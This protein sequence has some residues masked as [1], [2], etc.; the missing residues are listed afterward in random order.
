MQ[1]KL[2]QLPQEV[3]GLIAKQCTLGLLPTLMRVSKEFRD[4]AE[5][6]LFSRLSID[7]SRG[8][9]PALIALEA[10]ITRAAFAQHLSVHFGDFAIFTNPAYGALM[11]VLPRMSN[12]TDLRVRFGWRD[13]ELKAF[14]TVLRARV[15]RLVTLFC[16]IRLDL[17]AVVLSQPAL[18]HLGTYSWGDVVNVSRWLSSS[19]TICDRSLVVFSLERTSYMQYFTHLTVYQQPSPQLWTEFGAVIQC[20]SG[21]PRIQLSSQSIECIAFFLESVE[22][23]LSPMW[24]TVASLFP[25]TTRLEVYSASLHYLMTADEIVAGINLFTRLAE[26]SINKLPT[27]VDWVD[28]DMLHSPDIIPCVT[29]WAS[30]SPFLREVTIG[31]NGL[32]ARRFGEDWRVIGDT[33]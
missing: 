27:V 16:D 30:S 4:E 33:M 13:E 31:Q 12:L 19:S 8:E 18:R 14:E 20:P 26:I 32:S 10:K 21:S 23:G 28:R 17:E 15:F 7:A 3:K 22:D 11:T 25:H 6:V 24:R 9:V 2:V 5:R 29:R 1:I